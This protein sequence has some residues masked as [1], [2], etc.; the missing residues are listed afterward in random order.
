VEIIMLHQD[1]HKERLTIVDLTGDIDEEFLCFLY[2][3]KSFKN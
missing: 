1:T 3:N 2:N